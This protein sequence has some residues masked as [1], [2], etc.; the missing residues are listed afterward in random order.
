MR[1]NFLTHF[2]V[3]HVFSIPI[4]FVNDCKFISELF[5]RNQFYFYENKIQKYRD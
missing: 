3:Q 2:F 5:C 4:F 1:Q